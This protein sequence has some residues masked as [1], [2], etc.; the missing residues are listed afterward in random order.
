MEAK[1]ESTYYEKERRENP[2]GGGA[3]G[4]PRRRPMADREGGGLAEG[5]YS[6]VNRALVL[7][8]GLGLLAKVRSG[9]LWCKLRS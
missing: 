1:L 5:Q 6:W 9:W 3:R 7:L 8:W 4:R 2:K